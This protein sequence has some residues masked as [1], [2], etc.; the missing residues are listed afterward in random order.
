MNLEEERRRLRRVFGAALLSVCG[1]AAGVGAC[2]KGGETP[3]GP[4]ELDAAADAL[5]EAAPPVGDDGSVGDDAADSGDSA[6]PVV[7]AGSAGCYDGAV[8]IEAG[9]ADICALYFG[10]GFPQGISNVG[11]ALGATLL[12][13]G[14]DL[15]VVNCRLAEG[16]GCEQD[17]YAPPE[18]GA[19]T[20]LCTPCPGGGG[21]RPEGLVKER[22]A[23]GEGALGTYLASLA[24][25]EQAAVLAFA[26]MGEELAA[27]GAPETLVCEAE[28][29]KRD[30]VRH[31]RTLSRLARAR[32]GV[33]GRAALPKRR[34]TRTAAAIAAENAAEG[35]VRE[36]YG[37][38]LMHWQATHAHDPELRASFARVAE[39]EE[40]HAA[41]A[42]A[43]ARWLEARLDPD[44]QARVR[45]A[46]A[47][48]LSAL[49]D[50]LTHEPEATLV[51]RAGVPRAAQALALLEALALA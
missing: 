34:G 1:S 41:L 32:G 23:M 28:R 43:L 6:P 48:A 2:S 30:E 20:M 51:A 11:C 26:R 29:A 12:D 5:T 42:W 33:N 47:R 7:D 27:L 3:Q 24:F 9:D 14:V 13:G 21:R 46:R 10:C 36:T 40:R 49:R 50:E 44:A 31:A 35:C 17:V 18:S 45:S 16:A 8:E 22:A 39:D 19:I 15:T 37:A 4:A 38:L 25:E